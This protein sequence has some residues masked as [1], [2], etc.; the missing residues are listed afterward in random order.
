VE[1]S[2]H[3]RRFAGNCL[4]CSYGGGGGSADLSAYARSTDI[5]SFYAW[6]SS[7][8]DITPLANSAHVS[9]GFATFVTS[10][11]AFGAYQAK[12]SYPSSADVSSFYALK[13]A[14]AC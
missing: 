3:S 2:H 1:Q 7:L 10:A 14:I 12:G 8:P 4:A 11:G 6:K 13:S 9:S 5:N